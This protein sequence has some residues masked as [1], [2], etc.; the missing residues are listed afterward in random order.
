MINTP[1][2]NNE[3]LKTKDYWLLTNVKFRIFFILALLFY[4]LIFLK[5]SHSIQILKSIL[6]ALIFF[7]FF[8]FLYFEIKHY[9]LRYTALILIILTIIERIIF[10]FW[11]IY[12][13]LSILMINVAVFMLAFY[14]QWQ[15]RDKRFFDSRSYFTT[16][17]YMFTVFIAIAY[18][19]SLF[20]T[21]AQFPF[22]CQDLSTAS[23]NV[24]DFV[25]KPFQLWIQEA[26]D[27]KNQTKVIF[28]SKV[29][30]VLNPNLI[31]N[32]KNP[33]WML[34]WISEKINNYKQTTLNTLKDKSTFNMWICDYTLQQLNVKYLNPA[35]KFSVIFLI[36][37]ISYPFIRVT[38]RVMQLIWFLI[39]KILYRLKTYKI[40]IVKR[41]VEEIE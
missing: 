17:W 21:Y 2:K 4:V 22:T 41:E 32:Q 36:F 27:L 13:N 23:N 28:E 16:G 18:S 12:T 15:S 31:T 24:I 6:F 34:G 33:S 40:K 8:H 35:L 29:K 9:K 19:I 38:L 5:L 20:G 11:N 7:I 1:K 26:K 10:W 30:D 3:W 25:A 14:L 39:F 37:L